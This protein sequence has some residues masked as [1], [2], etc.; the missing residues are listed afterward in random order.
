MI[1]QCL[2]ELENII[3]KSLFSKIE[4]DNKQITLTLNKEFEH[5][6]GNEQIII[7]YHLATTHY[8]GNYVKI[9]YGKTDYRADLENLDTGI[10]SVLECQKIDLLFQ[11]KTYDVWGNEEDGYQVNDIVSNSIFKEEV[12]I[13]VPTMTLILSKKDVIRMLDLNSD[14]EL[15]W[16]DYGFTN[17]NDEFYTWGHFINDSKGK[18]LG[19]VCLEYSDENIKL[20]DSIR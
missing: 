9:R 7:T 13:H 19:E 5:E 16:S 2:E 11:L 10:Y 4:A 8:D 20:L 1:D 6:L 15:E 14:V 18:P 3:P 17:S 12:L